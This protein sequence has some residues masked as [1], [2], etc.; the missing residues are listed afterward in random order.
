MKLD[1]KIIDSLVD[2]F[3]QAKVDKSI[4][5]HSLYDKKIDVDFADALNRHFKEALQD[6][7]IPKL[8]ES[9]VE[10]LEKDISPI[11]DEYRATVATLCLRKISFLLII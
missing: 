10:I 3:I 2:S 6:N 4:K 1:G 11:G 9:S 5:E 8:L 7:Q